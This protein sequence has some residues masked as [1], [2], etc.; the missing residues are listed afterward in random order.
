MNFNHIVLKNLSRNLK[1]YTIYL[2]SLLISI[3]MF[4]SFDTLKY[5]KSVT[6]GNEMELIVKAASIGE[7]FLF[8]II[9]IFLLYANYLFL[10]RRTRS[11]ALFQLIGLT[12]RDI[13]KMLLFEQSVIFAIT[14]LVGSILGTLGSRLLSLILKKVFDFSVDVTLTFQ[15][16]SLLMT[17]ILIL[18]SLVLVMLQSIRFIRKH[19]I[20]EMMKL[21][22]K[23]DSKETKLSI[24]EVIFGVVGI[25]M[26]VFGYYLSTVM[27]SGKWISA[28]IYLP[29]II[30]FLTIIGAYL[31]FKSTVSV[32]FKVLKRTKNG[33][34]N[35]TD[36]IFTS[37][38]MFR[39]KK[40]A[41]S[42]TVIAIISAITMSILSLAS[43]SKA[44]IENNVNTLSPH[45]YT[46]FDHQDA[47][48]FEKELK[49]RN[50]SFEENKK[51][52]LTVPESKREGSDENIGALKVV[53]DKD[54]AQENIN[55]DDIKI[56]S[57][58]QI[59]LI[60]NKLHDREKLQLGHDKKTVLRIS[61]ILKEYQ[62]SYKSTLGMMVGI[63]DDG[64]Y[65]K[66]KSESSDLSSDIDKEFGYD[67]PDKHQMKAADE[68]NEV[69]G[70][71]AVQ[72]RS[73]ILKEQNQNSSIFLFVTSF[74]G[75][76]FLIAAGCIIYI[77]QMDEIEDEK[78]NFKILRKLGYTD[79]DMT[80]GFILKT[81]FNFGL[82]LFVGIAH[83]YFAARA[84]NNLVFSPSLNVIYIGIGVYT[85][86]YLIFAF[87]ALI[88]T[89]R[90]VKYKF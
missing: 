74:L 5:S 64:V 22:Q 18:T 75:V 28:L 47:T 24:F 33:N 11:F 89:K 8:V 77:K 79:K 13:F 4:F 83:T 2:V 76:I 82:P 49:A 58:S 20:I 80:K 31:F 12:R 50:V 16:L 72:S 63:V 21:Q 29:F 3:T 14:L 56:V 25:V 70:K 67:I 15:P 62:F 34:V 46:F 87:I 59:N 6:H 69:L 65:Q 60:Y 30:L 71:H 41:F 40:N 10:K 90:L 85:V 42:L 27:F 78:D 52:L 73:S 51:E 66:L 61:R 43:L 86:I 68:A 53:S 39:M 38:M 84:F 54:M 23:T 37:S 1:H 45:E 48:R 35:I 26:M 32:V 36:V 88:H 7:K 19:T 44:S 9:V 17:F 55:P 57:M 81:L